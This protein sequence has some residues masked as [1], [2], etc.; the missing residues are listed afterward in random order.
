MA[1][2]GREAEIGRVRALR[3]GEA[4]IISGEPG[5]GK[6]TLLDIAARDR[7]T[8]RAT[9]AESE[10]ILPF[11]GLHQLLAPTLAGA[12]LPEA[13]R[14]A[15]L[16]A[17]GLVEPPEPDPMALGLAVLALLSRFELVVV[18]DAQWLDPASL[19]A[20]A[21]AG[22]RL[23]G[24]RLLIGVR[25]DE[26]LTGLENLPRL[27]LGPLSDREANLLLDA[28]QQPPSGP[29]RLR[30]LAEAG[31]N[32]LALTELSAVES[33]PGPLPVAERL[34]KVF[35]ARAAELPERSRAQL[36]LLAAADGWDAVRVD[37]MEPA[38]RVGLVRWNGTTFRFRHPLVR[39]ALYHSAPIA[40]RRRAHLELAEQLRDEPDRYAWHRASAADGPDEQ[41]AAELERT[42]SRARR[43]GGYAAAASALQRAAELS[44]D[45][46][47]Q[48]RRY[49]LAAD[50]AL[51]T[52]QAGWVEEL[53]ELV[54][55]RTE[56][57]ALRAHA[58]LRA[59]Q[60][61]SV[62]TRHDAAFAQLMRVEGAGTDVLATAAVVAYYSGEPAQ[63]DEV[64]SRLTSM[65]DQDPISR[66]WV[67]AVTD[68]VA[69]AGMPLPPLE[70]DAG[71]G[72]E[73]A[74]GT[75]AWLLD[76][77]PAALLLFE[78]A[79]D[80]WRVRG[81]LP[82]GLG[83][84]FGWARFEVGR[85]EDAL[86]AA[87][88]SAGSGA[89][90]Q[91]VHVRAGAMV[92]EG[93]V[94]AVR[95]EI[96]AAGEI[97]E[98]ALSILDYSGSRMVTVRARWVLGMAAAAGGEHGEAYAQF[99]RMFTADGSLVHPHQSFSGLPE[100]AVAAVRAGATDEAARIVSLARRRL[101]DGG[102]VRLRALVARA[103]AA[104][105]SSPEQF[106]RAATGAGT[107]QWPFER[108]RALMEF[109]EWLRR[110]RRIAEAREPLAEALDAFRL[111]GAQPWV[112]RAEAELR[113]A[114]GPVAAASPAALAEL[115]PQQQEIV[116]LAARGFT[117][118][119]IGSRLH[120]SPRTVGSHLY[121]SFPKLG[122]RSR[123]QLHDLLAAG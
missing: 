31:G 95:G 85:W 33:S 113:A 89:R 29:R 90:A 28:L 47:A 108:A 122:V 7:S 52:G 20:L 8:L 61:L 96:A 106:F 6:S 73:I 116:R 87:V 88:D 16:G 62:T 91:L 112:Q 100:L 117:N 123:S 56:D 22:R 77:T 37:G 51:F 84:A 115:S 15:L 41:V 67:L 101:G 3:R 9:G 69:S 36:L 103:Q 76:E 98:R 49:A 63:L 70:P 99:R 13:K 102:S 34:V 81:P 24:T 65:T 1:V 39:S 121:R 48:A 83:C 57:P 27:E 18:D 44:P 74:L 25:D 46:S 60:A 97:A 53:A 78:R 38:E 35:A 59:G 19:Q 40:E 71:P 110:Q 14:T 107:A 94:H 119:E 12:E 50:S 11:A 93:A 68:P 109:A 114:G 4:L 118:R 17:F 26:P 23:S 2:V 86:R 30:V 80:R 64:R 105:A 82:E 54:V 72:R 43:R 5:A 55:T 79:F 10:M 42:A 32:P 58:E 104:L 66:A 21:F 75:V 45:R 111:L 92:M 120:L